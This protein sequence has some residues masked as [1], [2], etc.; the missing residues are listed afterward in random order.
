M[1]SSCNMVKEY[2]LSIF[3]AVDFDS[4][5]SITRW[6][7]VWV[8]VYHFSI[9][10][11]SKQEACIWICINPKVRRVVKLRKL[12]VPIEMAQIC[13]FWHE[14]FL[15]FKNLPEVFGFKSVRQ[16]NVTWD[17][18]SSFSWISNENDCCHSSA[19]DIIFSLS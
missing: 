13:G 17:L 14:I 16:I 6:V 15:T 2:Y 11:I 19:S 5:G 12:W 8:Y 9:S 1:L 7:L 3:F 4:L 10:F 18:T